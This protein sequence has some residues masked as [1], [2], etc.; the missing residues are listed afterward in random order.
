VL[1]TYSFPAKYQEKIALA[2]QDLGFSL[3]NPRQLAL[4]VIKLSDHYQKEQK[5]TPWNEPEFLAAYLAYYLPLNYIR[6]AKV[7]D[8]LARFKDLLDF[9]TYIDFGFGL[10]S[11]LLAAHDQGLIG[12]T[13]ELYALDISQKPIDFFSRYLSSLPIKKH[14]EL[15]PKPK[16]LGVFSYSL[17]ELLKAPTWFYDLETIIILEPSTSIWGRKLM[18]WRESLIAKGYSIWAP[19]T[20]QLS[21][22]LITHSQKDWCHD[23]VHWDQPD[24][25]QQIEQYLPM[26]NL[27]MTHSYLIASRKKAPDSLHGRVIGDELKEKGKSRWLFCQGEER[28]FLSWLNKQGTSPGWH[29][30]ELISPH[31][32]AKKGNELRIKLY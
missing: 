14:L 8:E 1:K 16:T 7:F 2:L 17:N 18:N 24:W 28:E 5:Q 31:I 4:S 20:H 6:N 13:H 32:E 30:G 9:E 21:C 11:S 23:R 12:Q 26:K 22:P 19:C 3:D 25:F 29:R 10:G 27:T 15:S